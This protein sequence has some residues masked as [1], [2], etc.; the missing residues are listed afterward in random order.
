MVAARHDGS[1]HL[2]AVRFASEE[3]LR[4]RRALLRRGHTLATVLADILAGKNHPSLAALM[5]QKPGMRPEEVLRLALDQIEGRRKLL[6]ADDDRYGRCDVCGTDLGVVSLDEM[7]WA[8]RC[9][10]DSTR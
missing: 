3:K 7:P 1:V 5:A 10:A 4:L 8:D 2:S 6:D 9:A